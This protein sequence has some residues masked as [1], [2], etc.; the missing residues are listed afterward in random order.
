MIM[1]N[2]SLQSFSRPLILPAIHFLFE[3]VSVFWP[4]GGNEVL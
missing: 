1:I 3:I 4:M 2:L